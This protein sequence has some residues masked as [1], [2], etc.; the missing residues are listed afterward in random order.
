MAL[1]NKQEHFARLIALDGLSQHDAYLHAYNVSPDTSPDTINENASHLASSTN[2]APRIQELK[3]SLQVE[4][5]A[6]AASL[7]R[8]L[9]TVGNVQVPAGHVRA[10]DKVAA[11]DKVA[12]ILGLYKDTEDA[13]SARPPVITN[14]TVILNRGDE[15]RAENLPGRVVEA[16]SG[17]PKVGQGV[18][19][20]GEETPQLRENS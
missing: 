17:G 1:T 20:D 7:V 15:K 4:A 10:A 19:E 18:E 5:L 6:S 8:E 14:I 2:V 16:A 9:L 12:K 11:L 13:R 3:A